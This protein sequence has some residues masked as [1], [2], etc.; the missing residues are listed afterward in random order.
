VT[1]VGKENE[2]ASKKQA[3][4]SRAG[5]AHA[6]PPQSEEPISAESAADHAATD[7]VSFSN[8]SLH[9]LFEQQAATML[10]RADIDEEERQSIMVAMACPCCGAGGMSF[11]VKLKR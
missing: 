9:E 7:Q 11:S 8:L 2:K 3:P 1:R 10:E 4:R 5:T 6:A